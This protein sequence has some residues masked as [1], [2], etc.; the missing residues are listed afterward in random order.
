MDNI[1]LFEYSL[2]NENKLLENAVK[3]EDCPY[4]SIS[5]HGKVFC[6]HE[7]GKKYCHVSKCP[8]PK[9]DKKEYEREKSKRP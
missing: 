7:D 9:D 8:M 2:E 3:K 6:L 5:A 4:E 1:K